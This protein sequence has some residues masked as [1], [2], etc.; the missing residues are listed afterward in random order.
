MQWKGPLLANTNNSCMVIVGYKR[1]FVESNP[2]LIVIDGSNQE[3]LED[4]VN[5]DTVYTPSGIV[6]LCISKL[7]R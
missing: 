2:N 1:E 5:D 4:N 7:E 3:L 6:V